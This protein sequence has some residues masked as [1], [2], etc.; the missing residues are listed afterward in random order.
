MTDL[1]RLLV[2][3]PRSWRARY[4]EEMAGLLADR[5][6]TWSDAIDLGRGALD[7]HLHPPVR[8]RIPGLGAL[9]A[10]AAWFVIAFGLLAEPVPPDWPGLLAWTLPL[11]AAAA[12]GSTMAMAG[13]VL[14]TGSGRAPLARLTLGAGL[15]T[16][17]GLPAALLVAAIGGP[18]GAITGIALSLA[19]VGTIGCGLVVDGRG[20]TLPGNLLAVAGTAW[21]LPAPAAWLVA[22]VAWSALGL[23][24]IVDRAVEASSSG[25]PA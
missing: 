7:A 16:A 2:L 25:H 17:I 5:A 13:I 20:A 1:R 8:S 18:Y 23:W 10:G 11:A 4:G 3:Y 22:G 21:L 9:S 14:G 12:V 19:G 6:P 15:L 24:L